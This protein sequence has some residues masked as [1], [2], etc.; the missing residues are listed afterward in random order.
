MNSVADI[1]FDKLHQY[2]WWE[3]PVYGYYEQKVLPEMTWGYFWDKSVYL[4]TLATRNPLCYHGKDGTWYRT[5]WQFLSDKGSIPMFFQGL[6]GLSSDRWL[7]AYYFHDFAC[8][9]GGLYASVDD[10]KTWAWMA[11]NREQID[12][13]LVDMIGAL[14]GNWLARHTI[15]NGVR[16]GAH[17]MVHPSGYWM[18]DEHG[19]LSPETDFAIPPME[20]PMSLAPTMIIEP[21]PI[22][23]RS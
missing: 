11:M 1:N 22:Q 17:F 19:L 2:G 10:G 3:N 6:P 23:L 20:K 12:T 21:G 13:L 14:G 18:L 9:G 4:V 5:G 7:V 8:G 16:I 15:Y